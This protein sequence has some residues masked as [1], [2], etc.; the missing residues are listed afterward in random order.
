MIRDL[1]LPVYVQIVETVRESDGLA[2][3]SRNAYLTPEQ[4]AEAV[5]L[6][7]A[8]RA[9]LDA[10]ERGAG[11]REAIESARATLGPLAVP[12]YFDVVD[13]DTFEPLQAP[14]PPAFAIGA[15]RY[16]ATRLLD[17]IWIRP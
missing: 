8:L 11:K 9:M 2:M 4:R 13:A 10:F 17:N 16:G 1:D 3:S 12:D 15:A 7:R 5:L 14:R 6:H